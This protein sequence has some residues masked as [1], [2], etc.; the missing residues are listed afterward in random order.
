MVQQD[1]I[2]IMKFEHDREMKQM[3]SQLEKI[4]SLIQENPKLAKV[5]MDVLKKVG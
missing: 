3:R 2:T 5:N 1:A 4:I